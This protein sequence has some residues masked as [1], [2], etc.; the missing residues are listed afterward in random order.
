MTF[1]IQKEVALKLNYKLKKFNKYKFINKISC[2]YKR[3]FN[4]SSSVFYPKPK[5]T[6]TVVKFIIK[7]NKINWV[8]LD[9][10]VKLVFNNMRK[11]IGNKIKIKKFDNSLGDKRVD[12]LTAEELLRIYNSFNLIY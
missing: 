4:V 8:S 9:L 6:S 11:K 2:E 10:F 5:V 3:C 7:N 12:E 1:M